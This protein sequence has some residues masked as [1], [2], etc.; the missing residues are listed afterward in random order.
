MSVYI[1]F[2]RRKYL[3]LVELRTARSFT[4]MSTIVKY[5][6][7]FCKYRFYSSSTTSSSSIVCS[8]RPLS[9]VTSVTALLRQPFAHKCLLSRFD[10]YWHGE[11][12][13]DRFF[14]WYIFTL[15]SA[16]RLSAQTSLIII[17]MATLIKMI[18]SNHSTS[19]AISWNWSRASNADANCS[20][21]CDK[22]GCSNS[23]TVGKGGSQR[24]L[25]WRPRNDECVRSTTSQK[26]YRNSSVRRKSSPKNCRYAESSNDKK[27]TK[28]D[29]GEASLAM[30][31]ITYI[32][33]SLSHIIYATSSH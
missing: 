13:L 17:I 15:A 26:I 23:S 28:F 1:R 29:F 31:V 21:M 14:R 18:P 32:V 5:H 24:G 9:S 3:V 4:Y 8:T 22:A 25:W 12:L 19:L 2:A 6:F 16:F 27:Y 11:C 20:T 33:S 30:D 7:A 10:L